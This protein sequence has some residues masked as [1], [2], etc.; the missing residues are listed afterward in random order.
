MLVCSKPIRTSGVINGGWTAVFAH[1]GGKAAAPQRINGFGDF[2]RIE[3]LPQSRQVGPA[4]A[5]HLAYFA[6]VVTAG[7]M[8][9]PN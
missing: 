4:L 9:M 1:I 5:R 6:A 7:H 3:Y 2:G 8:G